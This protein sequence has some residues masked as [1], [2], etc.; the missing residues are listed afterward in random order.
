MNRTAVAGIVI[1]S[2]TVV[3]LAA[4]VVNAVPSA[5]PLNGGRWW[6]NTTHPYYGWKGPGH[7][8]Y[9]GNVTVTTTQ[10]TVE[11]VIVD[12]DWGYVVVRTASGDVKAAT[13]HLWTVEGQ[14]ITWFRLFAD[15]KLNIGDNVRLTLN[16][17]SITGP[18]GSTLTKT[19]VVNI[20]DLST[21]VEASA[22]TQRTTSTATSPG[23]TL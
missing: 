9:W 3:L 1:A 14:T 11:G 16:Q 8:R 2:L 20:N 23:N 21:G 12:A 5:T 15:D 6:N 17:I 18:N 7:G 22:T 10:T 4:A 13:P 19:I